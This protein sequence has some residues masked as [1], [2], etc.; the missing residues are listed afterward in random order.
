[1]FHVHRGVYEIIVGRY[2]KTPRPRAVDHTSA[3][4]FAARVFRRRLHV[5]RT[6]TVALYVGIIS[7]RSST[8]P[9]N[10]GQRLFPGVRGKLHDEQ[11]KYCY[12]FKSYH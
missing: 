12:R 10:T 5:R 6:D 11:R 7:D 9:Y 8:L 4:P 3:T 1:M 2:V